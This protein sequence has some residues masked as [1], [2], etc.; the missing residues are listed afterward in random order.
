MDTFTIESGVDT[1]RIE[2]GVANLTEEDMRLRE[3]IFAEA[4]IDIEHDSLQVMFQKLYDWFE[5]D[6]E[7]VRLVIQRS[8]NTWVKD[9]ADVKDIKLG[10]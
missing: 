5:S 8:W 7:T 1:S 3:R 2:S 4:N 6:S 9:L 10:E